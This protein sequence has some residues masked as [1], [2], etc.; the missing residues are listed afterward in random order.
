MVKF[1]DEKQREQFASIRRKEEQALVELLS[2][3]Y[4]IPYVSLSST[5][6][7]NVAVA[8][9][10]EAQAREALVVAFNVDKKR[11][12]SLAAVSPHNDKVR[13]LVDWL[14]RK[15]HAVTLFMSPK[16]EIEQ[17]WLRYKEIALGQSASAGVL[18]V[19]NASMDELV[20][21]VS[22]PKDVGKLV[23][24]V[25][26][27]K[28]VHRV[29][30]LFEVIMAGAFSLSA[31]DIHLEAQ[32]DGARVRYRLDGVLND[33]V[34]VD[35][36]TYY[37][38]INRVKLLSGLKLNVQAEMQDGRF[39]VKLASTEIQ[40]RTSVIPGAF[41]ESAV[42]RL[43][44]P[45]S[46][47]VSLEGLGMEP[48]LLSLIEKAIS[49][50]NGMILTTGP[51]G[52][53]K[54]TTLYAFLQK[55]YNPAIKV[56]TIEDPVEYH[57]KGVSQTQ[58]D[59]KKN[60]TFLSGLRAALRQDPDIIM[61]GEIRDDETAGIA[62]NAALTGH[63]V[64]STLHTNNAAG[65]IPRLI[66]LKVNPKTISSALTVAM[67]QRLLRKLC[68]KCRA[69]DTPTPEE[70][71]LIEKIAAGAKEKGN[72]VQNTGK[73][74]RSKGCPVCHGIG[75]SGRVGVFEGV[76]MDAAV[77]ELC[78]KNPSEREI[79]EASKG[80]GILTM[81]EDGIMKVLLGITS[82]DEVERVVGFY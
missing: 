4:G 11:H 78:T 54:T 69:E 22:V 82:L 75:Y 20:K 8:L 15:G 27:S 1:D 46:I 73:I 81:Q 63:I 23:D 80:Q 13:E 28:G 77:E 50:P 74:W 33:I 51:T 38:L 57:L 45:R 6:I 68:D 17:A 31:S 67:A 79:M 12:V 55:V 70:K 65:A 64:F 44:D 37:L 5:P 26:E 53:G 48:K 18:S 35:P 76:F 41:G 24:K 60:Y 66:D 21:N 16:F 43:L 42:L 61:V 30:K 59:K 3:R 14:E 58:V 72:N 19:E 7:N 40:I 47:S 10:P 2:S 9:I 34:T 52:S 36:K 56:I 29:S 25:L 49:R 71:S 62:V 39:S 32:E